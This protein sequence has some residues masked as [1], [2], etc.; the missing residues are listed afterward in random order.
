MNGLF[1]RLPSAAVKLASLASLRPTPGSIAEFAESLRDPVAR[2]YMPF[3]K[4]FE[5]TTGRMAGETQRASNK[6]RLLDGAVVARWLALFEAQASAVEY[7]AP[8]KKNGLP[9]NFC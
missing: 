5:L 1:A 9:Y 4:D 7:S 2:K 6:G 3:G 8:T